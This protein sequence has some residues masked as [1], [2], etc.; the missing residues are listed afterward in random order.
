VFPHPTGRLVYTEGVQFLADQAD[1]YWLIDLIASWCPDARPQHE[2]FVQWKPTVNEDRTA[3]AIADDGN[4]NE[5]LRQA[6]PHM[7]FPLDEITL[8]L[9]ERTLLLPSEY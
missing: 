1:A 6:I 7:N 3:V 2:D 8:Y 9:T 5:L 4:G